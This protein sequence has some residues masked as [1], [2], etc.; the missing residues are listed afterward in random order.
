V[1]TALIG[2]V[3]VLVAGL[4]TALTLIY[5][6]PGWAAAGSGAVAALVFL[7]F[8]MLVGYWNGRLPWAWARPAPRPRSRRAQL[9]SIVVAV[10]L[11]AGA[12]LAASRAARP[13]K[14]VSTSM[15]PTILPGDRVL[16]DDLAYPGGQV[17]RRGDVIV[18][19]HEGDGE[20]EGGALVK[21]VVGLPGDHVTMI[22][23]RPVL[24]G[25]PV[26]SCDAGTFVYLGASRGSRG[27]LTVEWLDGRPYL[28]VGEHGPHV[29]ASYVVPPGE[30]FVLGDNRGI[31]N[32][33]RSWTGR[34]GVPLAAIEGKV[35]RVLFG[36]GRDGRLDWERI[37]AHLGT[38]LHLGGVDIAGL[39]A[40][41]ARCL[42]AGPGAS[43]S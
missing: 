21:R 41:I 43:S 27:R 6:V 24:N 33:S 28:A 29:F 26:P 32:D 20:G 31:S 40:G 9:V 12:A 39:R 16:V 34:A 11:A 15:V 38:D 35:D 1:R 23:S 2:I 8:T 3:G 36:A 25:T 30:V 18:F 19:R 10:A 4:L 22:D 13:A 7:G 37:G 42:A 5:V 17:P 14:I